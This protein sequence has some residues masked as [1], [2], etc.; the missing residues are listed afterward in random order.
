MPDPHGDAPEDAPD[1]LDAAIPTGEPDDAREKAVEHPDIVDAQDHV[2]PSL[3]DAEAKGADDIAEPTEASAD[4]SDYD[5]TRE[6]AEPFVLDAEFDEMAEPD[7]AELAPVEF[8][9]AEDTGSEPSEHGFESTEFAEL[10]ETAPAIETESVFI[11]APQ[12][13]LRARLVR[14]DVCLARPQ[15]SIWQRAISNLRRLWLRFG[16]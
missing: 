2:P 15:P 9:E 12:N 11:P 6:I 3:L 5:S 13:S 1:A 16:F 10:E 14:E 8:H 7:I 4:T